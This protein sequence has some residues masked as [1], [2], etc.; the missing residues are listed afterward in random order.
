[1]RKLSQLDRIEAQ[2][3]KVVARV[4]KLERKA[5]IWGAASAALVAI[6]THM[7]GCT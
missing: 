1:M 5:S 6:I 4:D 3:D 2:V 7:A